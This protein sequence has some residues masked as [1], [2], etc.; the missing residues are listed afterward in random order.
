VSSTEALQNGG[1]QEVDAAHLW[2]QQAAIYLQE[3]LAAAQ[4]DKLA[5]QSQ[6]EDMQQLMVQKD[7]AITVRSFPCTVQC[8]W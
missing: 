6:F 2:Q 1:Q 3:Q 5:L 8:C 7:S 4:Q